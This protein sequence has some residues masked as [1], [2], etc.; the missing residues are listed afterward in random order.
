MA[1]EEQK[2]GRQTRLFND[3]IAGFAKGLYELFD[4]EGGNS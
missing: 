2:K 3:I 4:D 1:T